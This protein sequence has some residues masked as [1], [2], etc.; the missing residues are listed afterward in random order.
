M[1]A[2]ESCVYDSP[3]VRLVPRPDRE[4]P[5]A[6]GVSAAAA[7][8]F[9]RAPLAGFRAAGLDPPAAVPAG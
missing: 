1:A 7:A 9:F 5:R 6:A 8:D 2:S 4:L 3:P